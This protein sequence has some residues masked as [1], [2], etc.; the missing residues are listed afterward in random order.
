V[1]PNPKPPFRALR[2]Q[3]VDDLGRPT[4][5]CTRCNTWKVINVDN[6]HPI[7]TRCGW[8]SFC[9]VCSRASSREMKVKHGPKRLAARIAKKK[10][11]ETQ[12]DRDAREF[13]W[14]LRVALMKAGRYAETRG[15]AVA[16]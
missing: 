10:Y 7:P 6:F 5:R 2:E 8:S 4:Y 14:M 16:S 11:V 9:R 1:N 15:W 3:R 12:L 13:R